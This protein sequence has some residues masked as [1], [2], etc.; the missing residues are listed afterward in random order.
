MWDDADQHSSPENRWDLINNQYQ[1]IWFEGP[2]MPDTLVINRETQGEDN[3]DNALCS[4]STTRQ[5]TRRL[6]KETFYVSRIGLE[7]E[8]EHSE[9]ARIKCKH[10]IGV[11]CQLQ[12]PTVS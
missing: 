1:I 2:Q 8:M 6:Y 9:L 7:S 11:Q 12:M 3:D 10:Y 4:V 5:Y